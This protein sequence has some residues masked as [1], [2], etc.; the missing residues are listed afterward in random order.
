MARQG[1]TKSSKK[2]RQNSHLVSRFAVVGEVQT[3]C[4]TAIQ[5]A[6]EISSAISL[7]TLDIKGL[8]GDGVLHIHASRPFQL[9]NSNHKAMR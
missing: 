8:N 3:L 2:E 6:D 5:K 1:F 4:N 7:T 9:K